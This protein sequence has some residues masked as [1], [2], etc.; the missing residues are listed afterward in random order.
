ML[1]KG[2][3]SSVLLVEDCVFAAGVRETISPT[4]AFWGVAFALD[5]WVP[6]PKR[7]TL[8]FLS[9]DCTRASLEEFTCWV[10]LT[11]LISACRA[12]ELTDLAIS[13]GFFTALRIRVWERWARWCTPWAADFILVEAVFAFT[14]RRFEPSVILCILLWLLPLLV[15]PRTKPSI[16]RP[17]EVFMIYAAPPKPSLQSQE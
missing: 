9:M 11:R 16:T 1:G 14:F 5:A 3:D 13:A 12:L 2:L 15:P 7:R 10:G 17:C 4:S 6:W 8:L